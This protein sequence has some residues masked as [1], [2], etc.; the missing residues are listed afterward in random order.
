LYWQSGGSY[1]GKED[2]HGRNTGSELEATGS[3]RLWATDKE[4]AAGGEKQV[5]AEL[6]DGRGDFI[7]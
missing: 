6:F 3:F 4:L 5:R 7:C 2:H 1:H